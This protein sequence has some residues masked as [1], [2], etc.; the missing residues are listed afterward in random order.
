MTQAAYPGKKSKETS[1]FA[2]PALV[3]KKI[4][5]LL[6]S[7]KNVLSHLQPP[8]KLKKLQQTYKRA[9]DRILQ[10]LHVRYCGSSK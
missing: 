6:S 1:A 10:T 8:A 5:V 9:P 2:Y 7:E 3:I 4:K